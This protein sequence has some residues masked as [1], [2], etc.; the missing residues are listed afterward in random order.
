MQYPLGQ[1]SLKHATNSKYVLKSQ[2]WEA[3]VDVIVMLKYVW[4]NSRTVVAVAAALS[5]GPILDRK[6]ANINVKKTYQF[7]AQCKDNVMI[8]DI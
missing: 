5:I 2:K 7:K 3:Y 1:L 8:S 6:T 4:Q